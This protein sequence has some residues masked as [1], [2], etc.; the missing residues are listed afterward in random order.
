MKY[1]VGTRVEARWD[2]EENEYYAAEVVRDHEDGTV[3]LRYDDGGYWKMAP[4]KVIK[5]E[6]TVTGKKRGRPSKAPA[7]SA[8]AKKPASSNRMKPAAAAAKKPAAAE[9]TMKTP[10]P[11]VKKPTAAPSKALGGFKIGKKVMA[12]WDCGKS[13][14]GYP[15]KIVALHGV[16][17]SVER[18][19]LQYDD[20]A[21]WNDAPIS[22]IV[23]LF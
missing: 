5:K 10:T 7:A 17:N 14:L 23:R 16:G 11:S 9:A 18:V 1:E 13:E 12:K 15:A 4:V 2:E 8:P 20:G 22:T 3:S 19:D 6:A 21:F